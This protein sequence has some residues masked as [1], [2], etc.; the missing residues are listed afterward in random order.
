[1]KFGLL[2]TIGEKSG[3]ALAGLKSVY[4][5]ETA[6]DKSFQDNWQIVKDWNEEARYY[7]RS[8][9]EAEEIVAAVTDNDHGILQ[10]LKRNW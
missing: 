10:W 1:M 3:L 7:S 5:Q 9:K 2:P 4:E 6:S 8:Q